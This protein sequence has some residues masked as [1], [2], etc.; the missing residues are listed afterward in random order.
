M[1][2]LSNGDFAVGIVNLYPLT[3]RIDLKFSD[4]GLEGSFK[5]R[6]VWRQMDEG[7]FSKAY[8][9]ELPPHATKVIRLRLSGCATCE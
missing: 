5:V 3:K 1:R 6:D 4:I 7:V 2:P 9:V 8:C